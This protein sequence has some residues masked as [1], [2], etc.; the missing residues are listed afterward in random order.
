MSLEKHLQPSGYL[1]SDSYLYD[2]YVMFARNSKTYSLSDDDEE[3]LSNLEGMTDSLIHYKVTELNVLR[4]KLPLLGLL[5]FDIKDN[6]TKGGLPNILHLLGHY[7]HLSDEEPA[8]VLQYFD[9][10][11]VNNIFIKYC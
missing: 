2:Q 3:Y 11:K 8:S 7:A 6:T 5:D 9:S 1:K 4:N 10:C